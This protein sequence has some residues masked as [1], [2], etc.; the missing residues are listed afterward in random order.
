[1]KK[2]IGL[3]FLLIG[4][5]LFLGGCGYVIKIE[6]D[7]QEPYRLRVDDNDWQY[8]YS[9]DVISEDGNTREITLVFTKNESEFYN[10]G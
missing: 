10:G 3:I 2:R 6:K 8:A 9:R 1:M 4:C 7:A 5:L